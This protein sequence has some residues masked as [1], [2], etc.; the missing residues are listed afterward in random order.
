MKKVK[1]LDTT[2]RDGSYSRNFSFTINETEKNLHGV[3]KC[4]CKID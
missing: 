2:L 1:I 3:R 4:W